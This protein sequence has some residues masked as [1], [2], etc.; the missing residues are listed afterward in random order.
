M[1]TI[2]GKINID[3][4]GGYLISATSNWSGNNVSNSINGILGKKNVQVGNP[5]TLNKSKLGSGAYCMDSLPYFLGNRLCG[6]DGTFGRIYNINL[7]GHNISN[8]V[9]VFDTTN[10]RFPTKIS[11]DGKSFVDDDAIWEI[12]VETADDHT[13]SI[14]TWNTVGEPLV[15]TSIYADI[16]IG[17]DENN[18]MSYDGEL[19]K[20][21]NITYPTYGI[22]S[23]KADV[24]LADNKEHIIDLIKQKVLAKGVKVELSVTNNYGTFIN[25]Q[26]LANMTIESLSY[27]NYNRRVSIT[28][29]DNL[30]QWQE[31]NVPEINYIPE[32]STSQ[33]AKYIYNYLYDITVNNGFDMLSF[34]ELDEDTQNILNTTNIT[35]PTLDSDNLWNEWD[36]LCQLC[37]L[38]I[39]ANNIGKIV[40]KYSK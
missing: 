28:V 19:I 2:T 30:E 36:K 3:N 13:I 32:V 31:I 18:L 6:T 25:T 23:N 12:P 5:F 21:S 17:I 27:D 1:I 39:Y 26:Q 15:I 34:D 40:T 11:V 4:S 20:T 24:T 9:I 14:N 29:Q 16:N 37:Y 33:K 38:N 8:I 7:H 22:I 35:Y 10:N